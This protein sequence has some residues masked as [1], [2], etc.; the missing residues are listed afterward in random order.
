MKFGLHHRIAIQS[1]YCI[2]SNLSLLPFDTSRFS[3]QPLVMYLDFIGY[4]DS[5]LAVRKEENVYIL[6]KVGNIYIPTS[7]YDLGGFQDTL[8]LFYTWKPF[9]NDMLQDM[10]TAAIRK[11]RIQEQQKYDGAVP[12]L[13]F[14]SNTLR[15]DVFWTPKAN[16]FYKARPAEYLSIHVHNLSVSCF[17]CIPTY[18]NSGLYLKLLHTH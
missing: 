17:Y 11:G 10:P 6:Q 16:K 15:P 9:L 4:T 14:E 5:T 12:P 8:K 18:Y 7:I 2:C 1:D 3:G 13:E